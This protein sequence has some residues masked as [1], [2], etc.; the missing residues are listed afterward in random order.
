MQSDKECQQEENLFFSVV[1]NVS[2]MIYN[3]ELVPESKGTG[4]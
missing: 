1:G 4:P 2:S 3:L